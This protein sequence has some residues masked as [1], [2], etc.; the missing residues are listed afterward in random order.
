M[1]AG[2]EQAKAEMQF[3]AFRKIKIL[4]N[5]KSKI[6]CLRPGLICSFGTE[7]GNMETLTINLSKIRVT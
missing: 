3:V 6:Q 4:S 1:M 7:T 2:R 5:G